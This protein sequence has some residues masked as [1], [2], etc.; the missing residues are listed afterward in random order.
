MSKT[1]LIKPKIVNS[2]ASYWAMF[3]CSI[4]KTIAY[5]KNIA[6]PLK[7]LSLQSY[8]GVLEHPANFFHK[9][10]ANIENHGFEYLMIDYLRS[11]DGR[12]VRDHLVDSLL[13]RH[14]ISDFEF[15]YLNVFKLGDDSVLHQE[16]SKYEDP[17]V[18][19]IT[20]VKNHGVDRNGN[21]RLSVQT[22]PA[23]K[24][25]ESFLHSDLF[26]MVSDG[27]NHTYGFV[28]E[29]EGHHGEKLFRE[30]YYAGNSGIKGLYTTF[31]IGASDRKRA[32]DG[33]AVKGNIIINE[34]DR[35][36]L[37]IHFSNSNSFVKSF[38]YAIGNMELCLDGHF[39]NIKGLDDSHQSVIDIIK[40]GWGENIF[41]L[42]GELEDYIE[43]DVNVGEYEYQTDDGDDGF[44]YK[45]SPVVLNGKFHLHKILDSHHK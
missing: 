30:S 31:A 5:Q 32:I 37:I 4:L 28:G 18:K 42:I 26:I 13:S 27:K 12:D 36:R 23:S 15:E 9:M 17:D 20:P 11:K 38:L 25:A 21:I 45:P 2:G 8:R 40:S 22:R 29:V 7:S 1:I 16:I 44:I 14:G 35:G 33:T 24:I 10:K 3:Y 6:Y 39:S 34:D 19:V 43:Y 41:S